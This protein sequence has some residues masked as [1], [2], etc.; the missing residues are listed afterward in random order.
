MKVIYSD[1]TPIG[2]SSEGSSTPPDHTFPSENLMIDDKELK[3]AEQ[4]MKE[5]RG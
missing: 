1:G 2:I 3:K 5:D 4:Q